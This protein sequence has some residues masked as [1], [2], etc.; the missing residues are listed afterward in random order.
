LMKKGSNRKYI[1][2][3]YFIPETKL[4][5][6]AE[7]DKKDYL[8]WAK[9][10]LLTVCPGNEN[11]YSLITAWFV[12]LARQ[13]GI[14]IFMTG[15]D[16]WNAKYW[17]KEMDDYG[18]DT[19]RVRQDYDNLSNPMKLV[20]AD[21][22]SK[23]INY[24]NNPIDRWCLENTAMKINNLGLIMPVKVNDKRN[25]RIDGAVALIIIYAIYNRYRTEYLEYVNAA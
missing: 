11:D 12:K 2:S 7:E 20:E 25:R 13:Y 9:S 3:H 1:F 22:R 21:L 14:K 24:N 17:I 5:E 6:G 19:E 18:L 8:D 16:N 23:L 10:N 4:E 15:Y